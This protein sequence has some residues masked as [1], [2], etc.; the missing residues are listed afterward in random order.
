MGIPHTE[1][2]NIE[3][4]IN[5]M[6]IEKKVGQLFIFGFT[7]TRFNHSLAKKLNT[8]YPGSIIVF[9]R[10][11][12]T[13]EQ[14]RKLNEQA[15][16]VAVNNTQLPLFLAVDQEGGK[17][18]RIKTS[19]AL[20]SARTLAM[21]KDPELV[22]TA[23]YVTGQLLNVLGFNMNLAPVLDISSS[24][25][26]DFLGSRAFSHQ[27][28]TVMNM[29]VAFSKGLI[30]SGI[31][32]TAKHFPGHGGV[33]TDSHLATPYK[34]VGLN[35]LLANDLFPYR[36]MLNEKLPFAIMASHI[37]YPLIDS[38]KVPATFSKI[39]LKDVL[40]NKMNFK[41][42]V[43]T[44]D[45]QMKGAEI[46]RLS[47]GQ[48]AVK[49]I[50]AGN[51][52]IMVGWN[53]RTQRKAVKAVIQ[54]VKKGTLP[55]ARIDESLR[56]ILKHKLDFY[57]PQPKKIS[58]A[59]ELS[60]IPFTET[61]NKVFEKVFTNQKPKSSDNSKTIDVYS[62]SNRFLKSFRTV[63]T[64]RRVRFKNLRRFAGWPAAKKKWK[65]TIVYHLSGPSSARIL[66]SAPAGI[67]KNIIVVNSSS[68]PALRNE[69]Q[70][71]RVVHVY[72]Y[73]PRL[74]EYAAKHMNSFALRVPAKQKE[75]MIQE[76]LPE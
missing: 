57:T 33:Q 39:L 47:V 25:H 31:L 16:K 56:R 34:Q 62:F 64:G 40:R 12:R 10:N 65:K 72:S 36:G 3:A 26:K 30:R 51:D 59:E 23:G 42:V 49:A 32:P 41:G 52:V 5:S 19:P 43:L 6:S 71:K 7:G 38:S 60:K 74:G 9:G 14:I 45:I 1:T 58:L 8:L 22:K 11:I 48:R 27:K 18:I 67:R 68:K 69:D 55:V 76:T 20:P 44:D 50:Q 2:N 15:Q 24:T 37:S 29:S 73:H 66:R 4:M 70:F 54:A 61:Y 63:K 53:Y 35:D 28:E 17:V 75:N 21:T 13:L 46:E